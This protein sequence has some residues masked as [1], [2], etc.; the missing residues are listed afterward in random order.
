MNK[1]ISYLGTIVLILLAGYLYEKF[2]IRNMQD[3]TM[4][5]Y[6]L[7][8]KF[9]INDMNGFSNLQINEYNNLPIIWIHLDYKEN[10]RKWLN[11]NSRL[12]NNLNQPYL[13]FTLQSIIKHCNNDFRICLIDDNSF[14]E[15]IPGWNIDLSK[16]G[17]PLKC[18]IREL[19][20]A[21]LLYIYGGFRIPPSFYCTNN[22]YDIYNEVL[23]SNNVFIGE[24]IN[25]NVS[26]TNVEYFPSHKFI[27]CTKEN[28]T[29][30]RYCEFMETLVSRDYTSESVFDG[31]QD[32]WFLNEIEKSNSNV[33]YIPSILLGVKDIYGKK[34][35]IERLMGNTNIEF[36]RNI[37]G[38]YMPCREIL[39]RTKYGWFNQ[40]SI[41]NILESNTIIGKILNINYK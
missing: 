31:S 21:K 33:V 22:L 37:I 41:E 12:T 29:I 28:E 1:Y 16:I 24:I 35:T 38:I 6:D 20:I 4:K 34:I 40:L 11:F 7:V 3:E 15:L 18:K 25:D 26:S 13:Y 36:H 32:K 27:A 9:L 17:D 5:D 2:K 10:A 19:A 8:R 30:K 39:E 14:K 23:Q